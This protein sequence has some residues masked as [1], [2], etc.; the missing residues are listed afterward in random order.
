MRFEV[1]LA[2]K[3]SLRN[4]ISQKNTQ[5]KQIAPGIKI[6]VSGIALSYII[7]L[8][9]IAV[10]TGFKDEIRTKVTGFE[11]QITIG[12]AQNYGEYKINEGV[13]LN[14]SMISLIK[15]IVPDA[16]VSLS[17]VQPAMLKTENNF[18]G[19]IFKG[20][21]HN[22]NE[23]NFISEH[24]IDGDINNFNKTGSENPI[25]LS[26]TT[27]N[28]LELSTG[29]DITAHFFINDKILSRKMKISGI[30]DTHFGDY[31]K[32]YAFTEL[33]ILQHLNKVDSLTGTSVQINGIMT[34]EIDDVTDK[35]RISL[36]ENAM[37]QPDGK[38]YHVENVNMSGAIYFN[39]L[40]LLDTNVVV[41]LILM[42]CVSCFTLISSLFIIILQKVS[43][44]GLL[45]S[46]GAT[47]MQIRKIFILMSA[48]ILAFG[49]I[50]GN[51][52][53][54]GI[55]FLQSSKKIIP[56]NPEAYYLNYVPVQIEPSTILILNMAVIIISVLLLT[57]PS[58][59]ISRLSPVETMRYD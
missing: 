13:V 22:S 43:T 28:S 4:D 35:L 24:I 29:N 56:L 54:L 42:G 14:D 38:S 33:D 36:F 19:I 2:R 55:L 5:K 45:K 40:S 58:Q 52:I 25:L 44:I 15:S 50:L 26:R 59:I 47:N 41:I 10:V 6:A 7:M 32:I 34:D 39:W 46:L 8:L 37:K 48:R 21:Q 30:Y 23:F 9:S 16:S 12:Q 18:E 31:D 53:G 49:L 57:I 17:M 1:F 3:L 51:I 11:Q 20:L 27:A